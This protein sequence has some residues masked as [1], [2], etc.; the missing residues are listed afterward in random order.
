MGGG[1]TP[2]DPGAPVAHGRTEPRDHPGAGEKP[3][4]GH[5]A[6]ADRQGDA[7]GLVFGAVRRPDLVAG[8]RVGHDERQGPHRS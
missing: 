8:S 1:H 7:G 2:L 4:C 5:G 6:G 3:Q